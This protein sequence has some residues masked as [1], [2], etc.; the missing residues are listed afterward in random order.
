MDARVLLVVEEVAQRMP[1]LRRLQQ[2]RRDLVEQRLEGVVVVLVDDHD[3][4]VRLLQCSRCPDSRKA[5]AEYQD[6]WS[7]PLV[8]HFRHLRLLNLGG[9]GRP[10][11][12]QAG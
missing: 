1:D 9:G 3:V 5:A 8:C 12:I 4:H 10:G 7:L 11:I 2:S 6:A